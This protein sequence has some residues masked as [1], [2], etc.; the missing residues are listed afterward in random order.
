LSF[1]LETTAKN[2]GP[3]RS[4]RGETR[5]G[6]S[7]SSKELADR[8]TLQFRKNAVDEEKNPIFP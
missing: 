4:L 2:G 8:R 6:R 3:D 5:K 1:P 7:D